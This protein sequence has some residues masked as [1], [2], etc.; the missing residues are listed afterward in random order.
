MVA[1]YH[2][3]TADPGDMSSFDLCGQ[4]AQ[5]H[6]W[7]RDVNAGKTF[8]HMKKLKLKNK[9]RNRIW[10]N[11]GATGRIRLCVLHKMVCFLQH[12]HFIYMYIHTSHWCFTYIHTLQFMKFFYISCAIWASHISEAEWTTSLSLI[13][14]IGSWGWLKLFVQVHTTNQGTSQGN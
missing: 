9:K 13:Y 5:A 10:D 8:R 2:Q 1:C 3:I 6:I 7:N 12:Y 11:A 14:K 4:Q